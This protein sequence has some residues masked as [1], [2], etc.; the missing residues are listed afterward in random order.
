MRIIPLK[1]NHGI[2]KLFEANSWIFDM[3]P[4]SK[5][6]EKMEISVHKE[7]PWWYVMRLP[8]LKSGG[9]MGGK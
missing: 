6:K 1:D 5:R 9:E 3:L 4:N 2:T 8:L 7:Y